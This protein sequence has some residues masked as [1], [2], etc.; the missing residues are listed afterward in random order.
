MDDLILQ[1]KL[2]FYYY[3]GESGY[4]RDLEK[5]IYWFER[6]ANKGHSGALNY[7]GICYKHGEGVTQDFKKAF[8]FFKE[9]TKQ[10]NFDG[11]TSIAICYEKGEGVKR[12]INQAIYW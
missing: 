3:H 11:E 7:L 8:Y 4:E 9:S 10:K 5:A 12:D 1:F 2:G 6:S